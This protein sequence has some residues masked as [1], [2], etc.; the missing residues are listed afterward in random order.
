METTEKICEELLLAEEIQ[1]DTKEILGRSINIAMCEKVR[2][3]AL[4]ALKEALDVKLPASYEGED[5]SL[6]ARCPI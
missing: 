5:V 2:Q 1:E 4:T 6:I 3:A